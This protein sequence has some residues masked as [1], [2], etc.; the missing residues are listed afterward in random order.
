MWGDNTGVLSRT[1]QG[2]EIDWNNPG[3]VAKGIDQATGKPNTIAVDAE[4]YWQCV[5][6]NCGQVIENYV[7]DATYTKLRELSLTFEFPRNW[8]GRFNTSA[9]SL[10]LTGRNLK[11]WTK[12]PNIDPEF[13][14][15]TGNNQGIEFATIA[16]PRSWG[17]NVRITP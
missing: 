7:Y 15:Q 17:L 2:R 14:Y 13:S 3:V 4:T 8:A 11:T 9:I 10:G 5:S 12:V 6:Y 1:V 16:N